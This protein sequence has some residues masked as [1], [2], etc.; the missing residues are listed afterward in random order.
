MVVHQLLAQDFPRFGVTHIARHK[1]RGFL[2]IFQ[3]LLRVGFPGFDAM[4]E[5]LGGLLE[6]VLADAARPGALA[7]TEPR[8]G[9]FAFVLFQL[10]LGLSGG[11]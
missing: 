8:R 1:L 4:R 10:L 6:V 2:K 3:R 5:E 11:S 7:C 9:L